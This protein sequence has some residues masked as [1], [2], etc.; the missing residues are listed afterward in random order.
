MTQ[1]QLGDAVGLTSVHVNRTLKSLEADGLIERDRRHIRFKDWQRIAEEGDFSALY[2]H[3][4]QVKP[5]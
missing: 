1:E 2:L 4:D 5:H 3:L